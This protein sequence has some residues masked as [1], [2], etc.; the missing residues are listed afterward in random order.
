M[1][2]FK[3]L[4][5]N[6]EKSELPNQPN[7][8]LRYEFDEGKRLYYK[9]LKSSSPPEKNK[10]FND[11]LEKFDLCISHQFVHQTYTFRAMCLQALRFDLDAIDDFNMAIPLSPNDCN[12]YYLRA[13]SKSLVADIDGCVSDLKIAI[14]LAKKK[15]D[16]VSN[17]DEAARLQGYKNGVIEFYESYLDDYQNLEIGLSEDVKKIKQ[18]V[19]LKRANLKRR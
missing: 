9:A 19:R 5:N 6:N 1:N 17:Y 10:A 15:S 4:F 16:F 18:E 7:L 2:W 13:M 14:E 11:A 8:N 3:K 12:L